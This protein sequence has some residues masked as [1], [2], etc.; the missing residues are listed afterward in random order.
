MVMPSGLRSSEP[1]PVPKASGNAPQMA[2]HGGHHD[3]PEAQHAGFKD[4]VARILTL[5]AL[6]LQREIDHHDGILLHNADEQDDAD[7]G[8][9]VE[10]NVKEHES[11]HGA[12]AGRG[13]RGNDREGMNQALIQNAQHDKD[14]QQCGDA[15]TSAGQRMLIGL[16]RSGKESAHCTGH[17]QASASISVTSRVASLS[18]APFFR[19]KETVTEGKRPV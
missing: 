10:I 19:L 15:R 9:H 5:I 2:A 12:D 11:Q 13:Q 14:G 3:G 16:R 8:D 1:V 17:T 7:D 6:G 18:D 4:G